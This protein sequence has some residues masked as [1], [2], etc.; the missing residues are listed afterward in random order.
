MSKRSVI[1]TSSRG[2]QVPTTTRDGSDGSKPSSGGTTASR[3]AG[4]L[5]RTRL[6][7]GLRALGGLNDVG[8]D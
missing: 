3:L 8:H 2:E 6:L 4:E 7:S 5:T 1:R